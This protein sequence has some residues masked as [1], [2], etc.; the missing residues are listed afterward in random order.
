MRGLRVEGCG[1][2]LLSACSTISPG[3]S[4]APNQAW[5]PPPSAVPVVV[6]ETP[7]AAPSGVIGLADVVN[8]ALTNNPA[9]REAWLSAR[10]AEAQLGSRRS[11]YLP[12]VD[13]NASI[14]RSKTGASN[15][16]AFLSTTYTP[17]LALTYLLY[18]FGGR[19]AAVEEA[20]QTLI[21]A[22]FTHNQVLQDVALRAEQ[23][24]YQLLDAKALYD[25]QTAT[26]KERQAELDAADAR[27][28]AGVATIADVLQARTARSQAQL[29]LESIEGNV[30]TIEGVLATTMGLPTGTRLQFGVL[31]TT[32]PL[33]ETQQAVDAFIARA[34][35]NRPDLAS[36]RAIA[37][38]A[39][40]RVQEVRAE[41]LPSITLNSN[42][43]RSWFGAPSSLG[44]TT[45]Y[46]ASVNLH[47]P[48]FTG[49]RT[50]YDV[51]AARLDAELAQEEV[52]GL[53][54]QIDLQV[55]SSYFALQTARQ[56]L[57][58]AR[59]L[60]TSAQQS[61]DVATA[62]YREGLGTILDVLTAESALEVARAQEVQSRADWFLALAQ[63]AH[64]TGSL[65]EGLTK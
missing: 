55:W 10:E 1:L 64:D 2:L 15:R 36:A 8:V 3:T 54:Q 41:G 63:L 18:D 58:T 45:P 60:L 53:G 14:T 17:S 23:A 24:Y 48:L 34:Q 31:P 25:A 49:F 65:N 44:S 52:R 28:N 4:S 26:V 30:R 51:R 12:E 32:V 6:A 20:R 50:Q 7:V 56:R 5:A 27:H 19:E 21:A 47:W 43:S 40:A 59:D 62:R 9:T 39:R 38:R 29:T 13:V 37:Q 57:A 46:S 11:E 22:D 35:T 42:L 33:D 16:P 61:A